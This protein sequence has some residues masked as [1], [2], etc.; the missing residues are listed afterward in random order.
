VS[1]MYVHLLCVITVGPLVAFYDIPGREEALFF[2]SVQDTIR[3][4]FFYYNIAH[5]HNNELI[6]N[7]KT[8]NKTLSS[9]T[10]RLFSLHTTL[11]YVLF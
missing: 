9:Y 10:L 4:V 7:R 5:I 1:G 3:D 6:Q 8:G 11:T 2:Y